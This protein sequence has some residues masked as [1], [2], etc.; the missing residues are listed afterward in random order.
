MNPLLKKL[1]FKNQQ[2]LLIINAPID[3]RELINA[4]KTDV[5]IITDLKT[6]ETIDFVLVFVTTFKA[7]ETFTAQL[8]KKLTET[9]LL[10]FCCPKQSSKKYKSE[11][12]LDNAWQALA[13]L[14]YE[15]VRAVAVNSDWSALR[16]KPVNTIKIMKRNSAIS[17]AGKA[18]ISK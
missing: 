6:T 5:E 2:Q 14:N 1:N 17:K 18:R 3:L 7:V 10:W 8:N 4:F 12:N 16:F 9:T 11:L 13:N 15:P